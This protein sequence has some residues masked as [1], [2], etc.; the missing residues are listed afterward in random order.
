MVP[1]FTIQHYISRTTNHKVSLQCHSC[2]PY[3]DAW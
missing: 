1:A 2:V 3:T